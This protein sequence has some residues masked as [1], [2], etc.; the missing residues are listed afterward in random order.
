VKYLKKRKVSS[1]PHYLESEEQTETKLSKPR[2]ESSL[3]SS[4]KGHNFRKSSLEVP[5]FTLETTAFMDEC[6]Q[7]LKDEIISEEYEN[8]L[9]TVESNMNELIFDFKELERN[10]DDET[11]DDYKTKCKEIKTAIRLLT[12]YKLALN[13]LVKVNLFENSEDPHDREM[14]ASYANILVLP[15]VKEDV[16]KLFFNIAISQNLKWKNYKVA[17]KVIKAY[18]KQIQD[19]TTEELEELQKIQEL[20]DSNMSEGKQHFESAS[21]PIW[22]ANLPF[23]HASPSCPECE[24]KIIFCNDTLVPLTPENSLKCHICFATYDKSHPSLF[25][26]DDPS[27]CP[28]CRSGEMT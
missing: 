23:G 21:C 27:L 10:K 15:P 12:F 5:E 20:C 18:H 24:V 6:V 8:A 22:D 2:K 11:E 1:Q 19:S 3:S 25:I 13:V 28:N 4:H 14:S 16:K 26:P 7:I 9:N 17:L